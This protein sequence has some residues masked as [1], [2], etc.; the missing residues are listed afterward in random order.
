M[1]YSE[2]KNSKCTYV[3]YTLVDDVENYIYWNFMSEC[4]DIPVKISNLKG[5]ARD[6]GKQ[7]REE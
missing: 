1:N 4:C 3:I 7:G 2:N 6:Y 5:N